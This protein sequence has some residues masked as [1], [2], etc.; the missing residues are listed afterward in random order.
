MK[1]LERRLLRNLDLKE[2][3]FWLNKSYLKGCKF[4]E[5]QLPKLDSFSDVYLSGYRWSD[6]WI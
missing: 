6:L 3:E 1:S 4:I 5:A 2:D